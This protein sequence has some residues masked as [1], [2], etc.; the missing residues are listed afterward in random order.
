MLSQLPPSE[1]FPGLAIEFGLD[2]QVIMLTTTNFS[3]DTI[4]SFVEAV[5]QIDQNQ[6]AGSTLHFYFDF[7]R[8][9]AGFLTPYG[10]SR[11]E[12]YMDQRI[13]APGYWAI[14]VPERFVMVMSSLITRQ[15][16]GKGLT[17][18]VFTRREQ[19]LQWL[20]G[21]INKTA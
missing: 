20:D 9:F 12:E 21:F 7:T 19:A 5:K 17:T 18:R 1:I 3:P 16:N 6:P 11:M 10:R 8:N 2:G 14:V 4:D 13:D 15:L